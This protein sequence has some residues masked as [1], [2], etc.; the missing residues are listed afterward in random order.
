MAQTVVV[1]GSSGL[2]G[3]HVVA[4][5]AQAGWTVHGIDCVQAGDGNGTVADLRDLQTVLSV[6]G[7][8]DCLVHAAAIP[9]PTGVAPKTV[10]D[11]NVQL[12]YNIIEA[13][14]RHRI[15]RIVYASSFSV[16]GL[17]FAPTPVELR[18][19]PVDEAHP[20]A[21]QDVYALSKWL[22]EE[23]LDAYVRRSGRTVVSLRL[24]WIHTA[25][26]FVAQVLPRRDTPD[27]RL[28]LWA[29]IDA[30][31]AADA[32]IAAARADITGHE[33]LF[34]AAP[35]TYSE[36]ETGQ[37]LAKYM[38]DVPC[39]RPLQG[40]DGLIDISR[41]RSALG[42]APSRSWRQYAAGISQ[43]GAS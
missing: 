3:R 5:F 2:L 8:A 6:I 16:L 43:D 26:S 21:P 19:L 42:F 4:G 24:P 31:D 11:T 25:D 13:A 33:R 30:E 17:P 36:E 18:Y 39:K 10:F 37:L 20:V 15:G 35:D 22:G 14:E 41:A 7:P 12:T 34:V 38:A 28:D 32:F 40:F 27:A 23:M 9:R 29:Y 1:T